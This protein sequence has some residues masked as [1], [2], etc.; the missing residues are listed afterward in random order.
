MIKH[1]SLGSVSSATLNPN[2]LLEAFW[3]ELECQLNR[4]ERTPEMRDELDK[5]RNV[6]ETCQDECWNEDGDI[7]DNDPELCDS[8]VDFYVNEALPDA[9][10][11][12]APPYCYF[13]AHEGDGADF[14]YWPSME[15]IRELPTY[16]DLS[17]VPDDIGEDYAVVNDHG[18]VEVYSADGKSIL[19]IV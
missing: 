13:G 14:G 9:L 4:Q 11:A 7:V 5:L 16:N 19:G 1:A 6:L 12:F 8:P 2:D 17:E 15:A 10:Q 18:N 3:N